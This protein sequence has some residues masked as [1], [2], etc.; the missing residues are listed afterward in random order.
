MLSCR[1]TAQR[2]VPDRAPEAATSHLPSPG[3]AAVGA[4]PP[5]TRHRA[6]PAAGA[7]RDTAW[8]EDTAVAVGDR[9]R[10]S[11]LAQEEEEEVRLDAVVED[12]A[13]VGLQEARSS[14]EEVEVV[15]DPLG[16]AVEAPRA[17][18]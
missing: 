16:A 15:G 9:A 5:A 2:C 12:P 14:L 4:A 6:P 7:P 13:V 10:R 18:E 3:D 1:A 8:E 11:S 17:T